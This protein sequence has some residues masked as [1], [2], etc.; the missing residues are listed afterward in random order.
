MYRLHLDVLESQPVVR[1]KS[2]S[3]SKLADLTPEIISQRLEAQKDNIYNEFVD[4]NLIIKQGL[5][6]KKKGLFLRRRM[7]LLTLGPH[8]YYVDPL[9]MTLKG[10]IPWS[11]DM[12]TEAKNFKIFYVHT[13]SI[14]V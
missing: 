2:E 14:N 5:V 8:L 12:S 1:K 9:T 11:Q 4:G 3:G 13:V 7:F 10:E 6:D